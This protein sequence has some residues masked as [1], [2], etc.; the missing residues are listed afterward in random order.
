MFF[1]IGSCYL[2]TRQNNFGPPPPSFKD[3]R[4]YSFYKQLKQGNKQILSDI[5]NSVGYF[6]ESVANWDLKEPFPK[7]KS[8]EK[9]GVDYLFVMDKLMSLVKGEI[10]GKAEKNL[11][12]EKLVY[13]LCQNMSRVLKYKRDDLPLH[14]LPKKDR[15]LTDKFILSFSSPSMT[16]WD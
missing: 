14:L 6:G 16:E 15:D 3:W 1:M 9:Y 10:Q 8:E 13:N 7:I 5:I 12:N 11:H 2:N 4:Q